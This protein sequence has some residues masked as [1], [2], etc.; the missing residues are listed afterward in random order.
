VGAAH[1]CP[2]GHMIPLAVIRNRKASLCQEILVYGPF[3]GISELSVKIFAM[4]EVQICK[5]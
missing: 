2:G 4:A 5:Y 3:L 1:N